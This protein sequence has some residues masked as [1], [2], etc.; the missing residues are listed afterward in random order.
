MNTDK[1]RPFLHPWLKINLRSSAFI[2]GFIVVSGDGHPDQSLL[3]QH[4]QELNRR[5]L[6]LPEAEIVLLGELADDLLDAGL[7]V[8]VFPDKQADRV[9]LE[10]FRCIFRKAQ[11]PA[12]ARGGFQRDREPRAAVVGRFVGDAGSAQRSGVQRV[13]A[14]DR[15]AWF[16]SEVDHVFA[17]CGAPTRA[18]PTDRKAAR[19]VSSSLACTMTMRSRASSCSA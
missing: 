8:A 10:G 18:Q 15:R 7:A 11:E 2:C 12:E 17:S 19:A 5:H 1:R 3:R 9:E 16:S 6:R 14:R 13:L 4:V